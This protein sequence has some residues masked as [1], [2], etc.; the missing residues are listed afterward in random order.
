MS[1]PNNDY[2]R[3]ERVHHDAFRKPHYRG[4]QQGSHSYER[5]R[6]FEEKRVEPQPIGDRCNPLCPF[7]LCSRNTLMV[8]SKPVRGRMIKVAQCRL[9]GGECIGGE[10]QYASCKLNALLP[11]GRC[12]KAL[13]KKTKQTSDEELFREIKQIEDYDVHDFIKR[14]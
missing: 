14:K 5:G 3:H 12:A 13:E 7:F 2:R 1:T 4:Y 11:D 6:Q 10:C 9:T 8:T